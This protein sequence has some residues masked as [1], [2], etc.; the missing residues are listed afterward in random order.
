MNLTTG[1]LPLPI[2]TQHAALKV[3]MIYDTF[4]A[5]LRGRMFVHHLERDLGEGCGLDLG[6]WRSDL[7]DV[8]GFRDGAVGEAVASEMIIVS[9]GD[10]PDNP[11]SIESW[12]AGWLPGK[13]V[14]SALVVLAV[15]PFELDGAE[16]PSVDGSNET[17]HRTRVTDLLIHAAGEA[18]MDVFVDA[19]PS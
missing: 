15:Q 2:H 10:D 17:E 19:T 4:E 14:P 5:G 16:G 8:P 18:G 9:L 13:T 12:L 1:A 11:K 6:I 3:V 7:L